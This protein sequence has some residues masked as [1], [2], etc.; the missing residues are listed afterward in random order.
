M[1]ASTS[2]AI[3][4]TA[5]PAMWPVAAPSGACRAAW[6]AAAAAAKDSKP[7]A[8]C[9]WLSVKATFECGKEIPKD[10]MQDAC[11][12]VLD[13]KDDFQRVFGLRYQE[14]TRK[15]SESESGRIKRGLEILNQMFRL[16]GFTVVKTL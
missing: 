6:R 10:V 12:R 1:T 2:A 3:P 7:A 14:T 8:I 16:W 11:A 9:A 5:A 4:I 15:E 13:A